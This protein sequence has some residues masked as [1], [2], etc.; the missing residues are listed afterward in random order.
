MEKFKAGDIVTCVDAGPNNFIE[1]G[2]DY[3]ISHYDSGWVTI[4]T[5]KDT[6]RQNSYPEGRF[7]LKDPS[8]INTTKFVETK[9]VTTTEVKT[10]IDHRLIGGQLISVN[11]YKGASLVE[12]VLGAE[13][14]DAK[15]HFFN[16]K[17]LLEA[18]AILTEV[19]K[20]MKG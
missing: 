16:K 5:D 20:T 9:T 6:G 2:K 18:I 13:Y 3:T 19:A 8:M 10:V 15:G 17:C 7:K 4:T 1:A 11:P 14:I 12:V